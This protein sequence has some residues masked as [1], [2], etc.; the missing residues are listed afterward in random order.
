MS[1]TG[2]GFAQ[3]DQPNNFTAQQTMSYSSSWPSLSVSN[4]VVATGGGFTLQ[5]AGSFELVSGAWMS[6]DGYGGFAFYNNSLVE[7]CNYNGYGGTFYVPLLAKDGLSVTGNLSTQAIVSTV[8]TETAAYA[9]AATD[10]IILANASGAA[11]A[12]TLPAANAQTGRRVT[13]KKI[14]SSANAVTVA[15]GGGTI[16]GAA[17]V[18]LGSQNEAVEVISDGTNW[19][20]ISQVATAIL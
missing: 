12:V 5:N 20:V 4:G 10:E 14:D 7:I 3:L 9:V 6:D 1:E 8:V 13:V 15:S 2:E 16:D 11:F 17:S 19:W 18:A